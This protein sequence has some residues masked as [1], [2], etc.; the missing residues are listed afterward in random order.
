LLDTINYIRLSLKGKKAHDVLLKKMH[1]TIL[2]Y[3]KNN[4]YL[5]GA[6]TN[7][8]RNISWKK[9]SY[10]REIRKDSCGKLLNMKITAEV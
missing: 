7:A 6:D 1:G 4:E 3:L 5:L 9:N 10:I 2:Q 8:N